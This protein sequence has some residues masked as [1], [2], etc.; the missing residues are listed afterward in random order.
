MKELLSVISA[1]ERVA[2]HA[3]RTA[4]ATVIEVVGSAY[5]RPG[6]RML[7]TESG[8]TVG[9]VSG[10][11]LE[12][13]V[14]DHCIQAIASRQTTLLKYDTSHDDDDVLGSGNGCAGS[15]LIS[16]EPLEPS[17]ET[18]PLL[19]IKEHLLTDERNGSNE[20]VLVS[21][22]HA[23]AS[24]VHA[25]SLRGIFTAHSDTVRIN[26]HG[27]LQTVHDAIPAVHDAS[28]QKHVEKLLQNNDECEKSEAALD[29]L[30]EIFV[31]KIVAPGT[32]LASFA[33]GLA[34]ALEQDI[35]IV[36]SSNKAQLRTYML[37]EER[38][39]FFIEKIAAPPRLI[40]F[41]A[42]H[43]APALAELAHNV[44]MRVTVIDHR[45]AFADAARFPDAESVIAYRPEDEAS[46]PQVN[47]DSFC[48][49]MSHNLLVD[50][51]VLSKLLQHEL[52][53]LGVLG[54]KLRTEKILQQLR[55]EGHA[56]AADK[57]EQLRCL[58][59]QRFKQY[60]PDVKP[61]SCAIAQNQYTILQHQPRRPR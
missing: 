40:I 22:T 9:S 2:A 13:D 24:S 8:N 42:G 18:N 44:G 54:P 60:L 38:I 51:V 28:A 34:Q 49:V 5:R 58:S 46:W 23:T 10:G 4:L 26:R 57:Q 37:G 41:G 32:L 17:W 47:S 16:V 53:Y 35:D 30:L 39:D 50:K 31:N 52:P 55:Q 7:V 15:I 20:F 25:I 21:V 6:A 11:C 61:V 43:D 19:C 29:V 36:S 48:V 33:N 3:E 59:W 14:I 56:I 12:R 45:K 27:N 1:Y